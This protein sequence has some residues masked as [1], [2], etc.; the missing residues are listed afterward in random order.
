MSD[1]TSWYARDERTPAPIHNPARLHVG[2][3]Y[4]PVPELSGSRPSPVAVSWLTGEVLG[5]CPSDGPAF[6][7]AA[8]LGFPES[9]E[10]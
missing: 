2:N 8:L 10:R 1:T 4:W 7:V 5:N 6:A 3:E 9:I